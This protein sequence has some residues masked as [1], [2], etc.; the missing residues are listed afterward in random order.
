MLGGI[1]CT[2]KYCQHAHVSYAYMGMLVRLKL[3]ENEIKII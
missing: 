2:C 1:T 3:N